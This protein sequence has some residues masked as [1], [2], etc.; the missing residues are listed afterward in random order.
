MSRFK[1]G[2][3]TSLMV[4]A[5]PTPEDTVNTHANV[6]RL[7]YQMPLH[8]IDNVQA[9]GVVASSRLLDMLTDET[10]FQNLSQHA[11]L[12]AIELAL[13]QAFGRASSSLDEEKVR[14]TDAPAQK[15]TLR[16]QLVRLNNL[17]QL[18]EM[19]KPE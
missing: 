13:T 4:V 11:R 15:A 14:K 18:P 3:G 10:E 16:E 1:R 6:R 12:K 9:A 17:V 5:Q 8:A 19:R 7:R 2:K